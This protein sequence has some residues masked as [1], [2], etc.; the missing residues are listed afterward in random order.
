MGISCKISDLGDKDI[1]TVYSNPGECHK[2]VA[3]VVGL[4]LIPG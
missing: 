3:A 1:K 4:E 2:G